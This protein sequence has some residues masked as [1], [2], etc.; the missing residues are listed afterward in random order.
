MLQAKAPA[1]APAPT[2]RTPTGSF[3]IGTDYN[4]PRRDEHTIECFAAL[5]S[6]GCM[7]PIQINCLRAS[8]PVEIG[9]LAGFQEAA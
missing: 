3:D 5:Q 9:R 2:I 6:G 8:R 7:T 4:N 1:D